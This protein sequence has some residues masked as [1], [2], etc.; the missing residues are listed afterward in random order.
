MD[1]T[2]KKQLDYINEFL[3]KAFAEKTPEEREAARAQAR[4]TLVSMSLHRL[5]EQV[6][7]G[8]I[9]N[10]DVTWDGGDEINYK[11]GMPALIEYISITLT[12]PR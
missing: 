8:E 7:R 6:S 12:V 3:A 1:E 4:R 10:L 11:L 5:A 2:V 9:V